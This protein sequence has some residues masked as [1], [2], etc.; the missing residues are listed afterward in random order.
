MLELIRTRLTKQCVEFNTNT[1]V[2][3]ITLSERSLCRPPKS[4]LNSVCS[5]ERIQWYLLRRYL[6]A[7]GTGIYMSQCL[8]PYRTDRR[9][10]MDSWGIS[11]RLKTL[12]MDP[13]N[14]SFWELV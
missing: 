10:P 1:D 13:A 2:E 14:L 9:V 11:V 4:L 7:P 8:L 3:K 5:Q 6:L 12:E